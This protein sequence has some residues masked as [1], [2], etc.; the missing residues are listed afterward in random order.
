[1]DFSLKLRVPAF[2][3]LELAL[4]DPV[5]LVNGSLVG[6]LHFDEGDLLIF[7]LVLSDEAKNV[8]LTVLILLPQLCQ[9]SSHAGQPA[10][11]PWVVTDG[12]EGGKLPP[13][14]EPEASPP[15]PCGSQLR[16]S[17]RA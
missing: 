9:S 6:L 4:D 16:R 13:D 7:H 12:L 10:T 1:M 14:P 3:S 15:V 8:L 5:G 11:L 17:H 2:F